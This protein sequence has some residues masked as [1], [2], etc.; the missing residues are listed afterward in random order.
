MTA[1]PSLGTIHIQFLSFRGWSRLER[2]IPHLPSFSLC[3]VCHSFYSSSSSSS[4]WFVCQYSPI[5]LRLSPTPKSV[6]DD[7][8]WFD[9]PRRLS[10]SSSD[11]CN[12]MVSSIEF[13]RSP[14]ARRPKCHRPSVKFLQVRTLRPCIEM[15]MALQAALQAA[16]LCPWNSL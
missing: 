7:K 9:L 14:F 12:S 13:H 2:C 6:D 4:R 11:A 5:V 16:R 8:L 10:S 15:P 3:S 1:T